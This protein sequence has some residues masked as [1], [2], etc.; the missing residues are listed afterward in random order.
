MSLSSAIFVPSEGKIKRWVVV[1]VGLGLPGPE[2]ADLSII[3]APYVWG[4]EVPGVNF[5]RSERRYG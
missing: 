5:Q 1:V 4:S 3:R 2:G